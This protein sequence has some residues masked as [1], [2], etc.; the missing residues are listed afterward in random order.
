MPAPGPVGVRLIAE[1]VGSGRVA[2]RGRNVGVLAASPAGLRAAAGR[3]A[4]CGRYVDWYRARRTTS[5]SRPVP[6]S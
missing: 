3:R 4:P 5:R 6:T 2:R 1:Y